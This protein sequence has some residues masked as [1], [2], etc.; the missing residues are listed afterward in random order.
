MKGKVS[1][2]YN[3]ITIGLQSV[4]SSFT[5]WK[6]IVQAVPSKKKYKAKEKKRMKR[7]ERKERGGKEEKK[8]KGWKE[9]IR[10]ERKRG[11]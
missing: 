9:F 3:H 10:K 11:E 2:Y 5:S 7:R 1:L 8:K 4:T 6:H